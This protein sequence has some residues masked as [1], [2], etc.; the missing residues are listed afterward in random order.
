MVTMD[1]Y[2]VVMLLVT[3]FLITLP[4]ETSLYQPGC[5][6]KYNPNT[7]RYGTNYF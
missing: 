4:P 2:S 6:V 7:A 3:Y 1:P 5:D